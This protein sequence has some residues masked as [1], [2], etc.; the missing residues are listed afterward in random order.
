MTKIACVEDREYGEGAQG[1]GMDCAQCAPMRGRTLRGIAMK[2]LVT[3]SLSCS[4]DAASRPL[5]TPRM[6]NSLR[7]R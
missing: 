4:N 7:T 2:A 3:P 6:Q 1:K 5:R